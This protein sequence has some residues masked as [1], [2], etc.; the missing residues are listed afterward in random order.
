MIAGDG[1]RNQPRFRS[2]ET[3]PPRTDP[4]PHLKRHGSGAVGS[5]VVANDE[6]TVK[7]AGDL[8]ATKHESSPRLSEEGAWKDHAEP[9][10][11]GGLVWLSSRLPACRL[12][13]SATAATGGQAGSSTPAGLTFHNIG[14]APRS[15]SDLLTSP[16]GSGNMSPVGM[17]TGCRLDE[18][19]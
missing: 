7:I 8:F 9:R 15:A 12:R 19:R 16:R 17:S 2:R 5:Q 3:T 1:S 18:A 10:F 14:D 13:P 4:Y 6:A 11:E